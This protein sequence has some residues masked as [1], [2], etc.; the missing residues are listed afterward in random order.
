VIDLTKIRA[1]SIVTVL[2]KGEHSMKTG[3]RSGVPLN[4]LLGRVMKD[5]RFVVTLA[6]PDSYG[7]RH[8]DAPGDKPWFVWVKPGLVKHPVTGR[9]YVAAL[10]SS[11]VKTVRYV[12]DGRPA[13]AEELETIALYKKAKSNPPKFLT[14]P[15]EDVANLAD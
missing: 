13:T 3:G 8:E 12:V 11:A 4:P 9:E 10:P 2:L 7:N 15:V 14:F 1:G 5:H 6:G